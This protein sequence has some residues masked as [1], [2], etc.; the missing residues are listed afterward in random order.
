[1][2]TIEVSFKDF[3]SLVG[4]KLPRNHEKLW[5]LLLYIK[6]E[7]EELHG[8]DFKIELADT[9]RPD[10]WCVEGLA[11]ALKGALKLEKKIPIYKTN[12]SRLVLKADKSVNKAR[13][14]IAAAVVKDL[15]F[16]ENIIKQLIQLQLKLDT[17]YGRNR[18]KSAIGIY[19]FDKIV[20][21][22]TYKTIKPDGISFIP[23]G[24]EKRMT[25]EDILKE[26]PKGL[27]F[28]KIIQDFKKYPILVD[29]DN[30]VL[31]MPPII[32][33]ND[34]GK[35]TEETRN[36]FIEVTGTNMSTVLGAL[37]IVTSA[38]ADRKG[39]VFN[40][41]I[42]YGRKKL[43]TPVFKSKLI[44]VNTNSIKNRLG[45]DLPKKEI[46]SLLERARFNIKSYNKDFITVEV[47]FY[48]TD[49]MHEFDII[50]D[51]GI[52]YGYENIK[53]ENIEISTKGELL[54]STHYKNKIRD[55]VCGMC[56]QE[57]LNYTRVDKEILFNQNCI[58]IA[59]PIGTRMNCLRNELLPVN[60][61]FLSRNT[62][63]EYPQRVY[64][65]GKVFIKEK[66][67]VVEEDR[68]CILSCHSDADFTE[69]KQAVE[70]LLN[71][72]KIKHDIKEFE[73]EAFIKGRCAGISFK[74]KIIGWFG[75]VH[76]SALVRF[77]L[78]NPA[79]ALEL[80]IEKIK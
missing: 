59:N 75:E 58:E 63:N 15:K 50:E 11:R 73:H 71:N 61:L 30:K 44:Y 76:P 41:K 45:L 19:D 3:Q 33:S 17:T 4:K 53:S 80:K 34:V 12:T 9:N 7:V 6:S 60:L 77:G 62:H 13:P 27:E 8:D 46:T 57:L 72:L 36:V 40:V 51:I 52:M 69:M 38:L 35:V 70:W 49:V 24:F 37:N 66:N 48:R 42:D 68:L 65:V 10:L 64:E 31:S 56:Y 25:P 43:N 1:M 26:H 78:E 28:G 18:K 14:F 16:D 47:P 23:L 32:N 54:E 20:F 79:C 21:P 74:N 39:K 67:E 55:L 29:A 22:V 2:P 5:D